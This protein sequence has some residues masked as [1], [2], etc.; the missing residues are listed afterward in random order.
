[1]LTAMA[2]LTEQQILALNPAALKAYALT[3]KTPLDAARQQIATL[4]D[5]VST[6]FAGSGPVDRTK[7]LDAIKLDQ[8]I[9]NVRDEYTEP[10]RALSHAVGS[11]LLPR[12][13]E[14][15]GNPSDFTFIMNTLLG[16]QQMTT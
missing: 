7:A 5:I 10:I 6:E 15:I 14:K 4:T 11:R 1:M 9:A 3:L 2:W 8:Q 16:L 13:P 12:F